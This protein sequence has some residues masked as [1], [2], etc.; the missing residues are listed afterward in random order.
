MEKQEL[1]TTIVLGLKEADT[2][3]FL[4]RL[5]QADYMVQEKLEFRDNVSRSVQS[6]L[7]ALEETKQMMKVEENRH[8][9]DGIIDSIQLFNNSFTDFVKAKDNTIKVR[10]DFLIAAT[11]F[12]N[13]IDNVLLS[14]ETYYT[15]NQS[16]F[17]EFGRYREAKSLKDKF[18]ELR[19]DI[20]MYNEHPTKTKAEEINNKIDNLQSHI[21]ELQKIMLSAETQQYL[22]VLDSQFDTYRMLFSATVNDVT[23][24]K[25]TSQHIL[26]NANRASEQV[27]ALVKNEL[28]V[29]KSVQS[30]LEMMTY[31]AIMFSVVLSAGL[32]IWLV[33][34]IMQPLSQSVGFAQQIAQGNLTHHIDL[35]GN[36]EFTTLNQAL[37]QSSDSLRDII[38]QVKNLSAVLADSSNA[39]EGSVTGSTQSVQ[40]QQTETENIATAINE[41]TVAATQI[42]A[43]ADQ[44]SEQSDHATDAA[45]TGNEVVQ[46]TS[47]AMNALS[48]AMLRASNVVNKL[49][50][51]TNNIGNILGVIRGIADQT[52][53]L[54]LNAA[55]EAARAGE[56]GR[57]FAV[58]A[59]EV[60]SLAQKTQDSI[61]DITVIIEAIQAGASD[62]VEVVNTSTEQSDKVQVLSRRSGDA[63]KNIVDAI[64]VITDMN[65]QVS[66]G[67]KEQS[68][69]AENI[70]TNILQIKAIADENAAGLSKIQTQINNQ[71]EQTEALN[72]VIAFFRI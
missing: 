26:D 25:A 48:D 39:I 8:K 58:V 15:A 67:A 21:L 50:E 69:V 9:V 19:V 44:A 11:N 41:M 72:K 43:N 45:S 70:N 23:T 62:V 55:I 68:V 54:A 61:E 1:Q 60:R 57:G 22:K 40:L 35:K 47:D 13:T 33:R 31:A 42:S 59:D 5:A 28:S 37:N 34:S 66:V 46:N 29:A 12:S 36:D 17:A 32:S 49:N 63:Y 20:W 4:A 71:L 53:L 16:D 65:T 24:I 2:K 64:S 56:Q 30:R 6:A 3:L 14:I 10:N 7:E 52:N 18:N 27:Y 38:G 51:D